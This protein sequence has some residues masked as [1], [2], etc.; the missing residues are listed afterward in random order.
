MRLKLGFRGQKLEVTRIDESPLIARIRRDEQEL[1]L[2]LDVKES[3]SAGRI[4]LAERVVPY[5]V[6]QTSSHVWVSIDGK[7]F[8]FERLQGE[9]ED[10]PDEASDFKAPMPGKVMD[11]LV[12]S[13]ESVKKG[14]LLVIMEAMKMEH[15]M[16]APADGVVQQVYVEIGELVREGVT[17]LDFEKS[18]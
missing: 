12:E 8:C 6:T 3:E 17:L 13:G 16:M 14:A 18:D 7:T 15:R 2:P 4:R 5:F 9:V 1:E 11:V 10:R